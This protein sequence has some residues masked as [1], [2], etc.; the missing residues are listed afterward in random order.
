MKPGTLLPLY[1][2]IFISS[3]GFA[4]MITIFTPMLI[5]PNWH[6]IP[7]ETS[8]TIRVILLGTLL[9]FYPLGQFFGG[10]F[11]IHYS[12]RYGRKPVFLVTLFITACAY[13]AIAFC[14][15]FHFLAA[16]YGCVLIAGLSESNLMLAEC[17]ISDFALPHHHRRLLTYIHVFWNGA[18]IFG[19]IFATIFT[20]RAIEPWFKLA[21]PFAVISLLLFISSGWIFAFFAETKEKISAS[22]I[23]AEKAY[24]HFLTF[25]TQKKMSSY[26]LINF[27]F[28]LG[29]F[30]FLRAYPM[31]LVHQFHLT[32]ASLAKYIMWVAIPLI[33]A[34]FWFTD[35]IQKK[36]SPKVVLISAGMMTSIFMV[37][38][39]LP[40]TEGAYLWITL[41]FTAFGI[42]CL[43]P[44]CPFFITRKSRHELYGEVLAHDET[45][46]VG[47]EAIANVWRWLSCSR[48][49]P[50]SPLYVCDCCLH[51]S[52]SL[53]V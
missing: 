49:H 31:H 43:M 48:F 34:D 18:Y 16:L 3:F 6:I 23:P 19:P 25:F 37:L 27:F 52:G 45:L 11:V 14:L 24:K 20:S 38:T 1:A 50:L 29:I 47:T 53:G 33:V 40:I 7:S 5:D 42:G 2:V 4:C 46:R 8:L 10:P 51:S 30:G 36:I 22:Y 12:E 41:F 9:G 39:A 44:V 15:H 13:A 28:Y 32:V 21:I 35:W 17:A 26:Y